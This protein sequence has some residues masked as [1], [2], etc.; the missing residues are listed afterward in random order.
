MSA[1][2]K[3]SQSSALIRLKWFW[4]KYSLYL[5][6]AALVLILI[7]CFVIWNTTA[8]LSPAATTEKVRNSIQKMSSEHFKIDP[9]SVSDT[10]AV[11]KM[12]GEKIELNGVLLHYTPE[13]IGNDE[14]GHIVIGSVNARCDA[15]AVCREIFRFLNENPLKCTGSLSIGELVC[16]GV[17]YEN[18]ELTPDAH[19]SWVYAKG[20]MNGAELE[21]DFSKEL[22]TL[23]GDLPCRSS[24]LFPE[25]EGFMGQTFWS[26]VRAYEEGEV[27][28]V[29]QMEFRV[30]EL[31]LSLAEKVHPWQ[32]VIKL[33]AGE[34]ATYD[35]AGGEFL[36]TRQGNTLKAKLDA[37]A[38]SADFEIN[39]PASQN[40]VYKGKY[41]RGGKIIGTGSMESGVSFLPGEAAKKTVAL[42]DDFEPVCVTAADYQKK[43]AAFTLTAPLYV[44][45]SGGVDFQGGSLVLNGTGFT[46]KDV[47]VKLEQ[48]SAKKGTFSLGSVFENGKKIGSVSGTID[49]GKI[50]GKAL[51]YGLDGS[52]TGTLAEN[53]ETL[54]YTLTFP[55]QQIKHAG[56]DLLAGKSA[57]RLQGFATLKMDHRGTF[58]LVIDNGELDLAPAKLSNFKVE[59]HA[60]SFSFDRAAFCGLLLG[61]GQGKY[62][63]E[64]GKFRLDGMNFDWCGGTCTLLP[65][66]EKDAF[67]LSCSDLLL[68]DLFK[69]LNVGD[70]SGAGRVTGKIPLTIGADGSL[71]PGK[72]SLYSVPGTSEML[73]GTLNENYKSGDPAYMFVAD[74]MHNMKYDWVKLDFEPAAD[75]GKYVLRISFRGKPNGPLGYELV[76]GVNGGTMIRKSEKGNNFGYLNLNLNLDLDLDPAALKGAFRNLHQ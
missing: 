34:L 69:M 42:G 27:L 48:G 45:R 12:R 56:R 43:C 71:V 49:G 44:S 28:A 67:M 10:S 59:T 47:T 14:I 7:L 70:F 50:T 9:V 54:E 11:L 30:R 4:Q 25:G 62:H 52:L 73:K 32:R 40:L 8:E 1:K 20:T 26:K 35:A 66:L 75:G 51:L 19:R 33:D 60:R 23:K 36:C 24:L 65:R 76:P 53:G 55:R 31:Q 22:L 64:Q 37:A 6:G 58:E 17:R 57:V 18:I 16:N 2:K 68:T 15:A 38:D 21:I 29:D 72:F 61:K 3:K 5:S 41:Q 46:V 39:A 13:S 63:L 74:V